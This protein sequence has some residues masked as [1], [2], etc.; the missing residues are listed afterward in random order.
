QFDIRNAVCYNA[1]YHNFHASNGLFHYNR[2]VQTS[3]PNQ[4]TKSSLTALLAA[5]QMLSIL[6]TTSCGFVKVL[7][8][9]FCSGSK[10]QAML[11]DIGLAVLKSVVLLVVYVVFHLVFR[12]Q[13]FVSEF[14]LT[15]II[16]SPFF[17]VLALALG[18]PLISVAIGIHFGYELGLTQGGTVWG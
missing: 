3:S 16:A 18:I 14:R 13:E 4:I 2:S 11:T 1:H 9:M 6:Q 15:I 10:E 7:G 5:G 17:I 8:T 12:R